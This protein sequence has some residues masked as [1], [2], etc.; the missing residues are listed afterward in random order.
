MA[1]HN[2]CIW[3]HA[4]QAWCINPLSKGSYVGRQTEHT[5]K[6]RLLCLTSVLVYALGGI[7][8]MI[9]NQFSSI[10]IRNL[11]MRSLFH[12]SVCETPIANILYIIGQQPELSWTGHLLYPICSSKAAVMVNVWNTSSLCATITGTRGW[13]FWSYVCALYVSCSQSLII[14]YTCCF[15]ASRV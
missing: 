9:V 1:L 14:E 4:A 2:V 15:I 10:H 7:P 12:S 8:Y 5:T 11:R 6:K 13:V 3:L